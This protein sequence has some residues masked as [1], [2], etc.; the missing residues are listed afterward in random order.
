M[1]NL[2]PAEE[3]SLSLAL[4]HPVEFTRH[5]LVLAADLPISIT[6]DRLQQSVDHLTAAHPILRTSYAST[7][8]GLQRHV[9]PHLQHRVLEGDASKLPVSNGP[10]IQSSDLL[11]FGVS[12]DHRT[13]WIVAH[14]MLLDTAS[15]EQ[16]R[17]AL[18]ASLLSNPDDQE[19]PP[20][21]SFADYVASLPDGRQPSPAW[22][23]PGKHTPTAGPRFGERVRVLP[24]AATDGYRRICREHKLT[25]FMT[26]V[27][28]IA[29]QL[30]HSSG[31]PQVSV[32]TA[33]DRRPRSFAGVLGNF[34]VNLFL[35]LTAGATFADTAGAARAAVLAGLR[36]SGEDTTLDRAPMLRCHYLAAGR[37]YFTVLDD[38]QPGDQWD[39]TTS[40]A[41]WP[42]DI[43]FAED[44]HRRI[45]LWQQWDRQRWSDREVEELAVHCIQEL[46]G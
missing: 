44:Q 18:R 23:A 9:H 1:R 13:A 12:S 33:V 10:R 40:T 17:Q 3:E 25:P 38:H 22:P 20:A 11:R 43:G 5:A 4:E 35:Q 39:E 14:E 29:S 34:S 37:H 27:A 24:A 45:G 46:A 28:V 2:A 7:P 30:A 32:A 41:G 6:T 19:P 42:L 31:S 26:A 15:A 36:P 21:A 8:D 16:L